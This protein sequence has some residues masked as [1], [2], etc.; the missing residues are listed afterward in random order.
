MSP[1]YRSSHPSFFVANLRTRLRCVYQL[2]ITA[3]HTAIEVRSLAAPKP[4]LALLDC[5]RVCARDSKSKQFFS[6]PCL[7]SFVWFR[8]KL[9]IDD[10]RLRVAFP[11]TSRDQ[12]SRGLKGM[13]DSLVTGARTSATKYERFV[14]SALDAL[15]QR[16][17]L[18]ISVEYGRNETT[19][20][21]AAADSALSV[22][23]RGVVVDVLVPTLSAESA[24]SARGR[25]L[26]DRARDQKRD[27]RLATRGDTLSVFNGIR[28]VCGP[29]RAGHICER[30]GVS[31]D[32]DGGVTQIVAWR[33]IDAQYAQDR[34]CQLRMMVSADDPSLI[35]LDGLFSNTQKKLLFVG[36]KLKVRPCV[37]SGSDLRPQYFPQIENQDGVLFADDL[38]VATLGGIGRIVICPRGHA[39][40]YR[41]SLPTEYYGSLGVFCDGCRDS[42]SE[43]K[44]F[45]H[46]AIFPCANNDGYDLCRSCAKPKSPIPASNAVNLTTTTDTE[47]G[48]SDVAAIMPPSSELSPAAAD[49]RLRTNGGDIT[50]DVEDV[51]DNVDNRGDGGHSGSDESGEESDEQRALEPGSRDLVF[52][53]LPEFDGEGLCAG[54]LAR[55]TSP[56]GPMLFAAS[57]LPPSLARRATA[58]K[59]GQSS[60]FS[61]HPH[62]TSIST[63]ARVTLAAESSASTAARLTLAAES[64]ASTAARLTLAAERSASIAAASSAAAISVSTDARVAEAAESSASA[65]AASSAAAIAA[66]ASPSATADSASDDSRGRDHPVTPVAAVARSIASPRISPAPVGSASS[67]ASA[68]AAAFAAT[69]A[70]LDS[71]AKTSLAA[72]AAPAEEAK[73]SL[74][75]S[76]AAEPRG[77][78]WRV[79]EIHG[80]ALRRTPTSICSR[81]IRPCDL[82]RNSRTAPAH[83]PN[84]TSTSDAIP[85]PAHRSTCD[86]I[87]AP[88]S[89]Y[90]ARPQ[91]TP[92][93]ITE[94]SSL[95]RNG[96][97]WTPKPISESTPDPGIADPR[98]ESTPAP[99]Q[100]STPDQR[101]EPAHS[102]NESNPDPRAEPTL[103]LPPNSGHESRPDPRP[104]STLNLALNSGHESRPDTRPESTLNSAPSSGH[105][106]RPDTRPESTL[107]S[108]PSSG[109]ESR[110]DP[111]PESTLNLASARAPGPRFESALNLTSPR[112]ESVN[113]GRPESAQNPRSEST[114]GPSSD[115]NCVSLEALLVSGGC[116]GMP[117][118]IWSSERR[119]TAQLR[120]C[121]RS[122][123]APIWVPVGIDLRAEFLALHRHVLIKRRSPRFT[124]LVN[125]VAKQLHLMS[126]A[127]RARR[128]G[129]AAALGHQLLQL[130][131]ET[132]LD[133]L[134]VECSSEEFGTCGTI[135]GDVRFSLA[136]SI[137]MLGLAE[138]A[139]AMLQAAVHK[140]R[141]DDWNRIRS[142]PDFDSLHDRPAFLNLCNGE[143]ADRENDSLSSSAHSTDA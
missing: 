139:M 65:A 91:S 84:P 52:L 125:E 95:T 63:D 11:Q 75:A 20:D 47:S 131:G 77:A 140:G 25:A 43:S 24:G 33:A 38:A 15:R 111:R 42:I 107:N 10:N 80:L 136:R 56:R 110:P 32:S 90:D 83:V 62:P 6:E 142:Q 134:A 129:E 70:P 9:R 27:E 109:H 23:N 112:F 28:S 128:Y 50:D 18:D 73:S 71:E 72:S 94:P 127:H 132:V 29:T 48:R 51:Q 82:G 92:G 120:F 89:T 13:A 4:I 44:G 99:R 130:H 46:C 69:S 58:A 113:S 30:Y 40:H 117:H 59:C 55:R 14:R 115:A 108:A 138:D 74:A 36:P 103:N 88:Q 16:V 133:D 119:H 21:S 8:F 22:D 66:A 2:Q 81:A 17:G 61:A 26:G 98:P 79:H 86:A 93:P 122:W 106:S 101:T 7:A 137:N 37:W 141:F 124:R 102:R 126:Q 116:D 100:G 64:S 96:T 114:A 68:G 97:E 45:Y 76:L 1:C 34:G 3:V 121:G 31:V 104:E 87:P 41:T 39:M 35:R 78:Y 123:A 12:T 53:P 118:V 57:L 60:P 19:H 54:I 85:I 105:E 67:S 143:L 135:G 5:V 49:S